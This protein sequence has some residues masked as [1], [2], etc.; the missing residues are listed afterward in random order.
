MLLVVL[1][2]AAGSVAPPPA[3]MGGG[4]EGCRSRTSS[5][6]SPTISTGACFVHT[7]PG[8]YAALRTEDHLYVQHRNGSRELYDLSRDPYELHNLAGSMRDGERA[9]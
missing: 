2:G 3:A 6:S 5:S 1:A 4:P 8:T 7:V 9:R